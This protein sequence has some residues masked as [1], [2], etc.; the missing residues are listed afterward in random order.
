MIKTFI[1]EI[2]RNCF[3]T[4]YTEVALLPSSIFAIV[5]R[6]Y[7]YEQM[8]LAVICHSDCWIEMINPVTVWCEEN[9]KNDWHFSSNFFYFYDKADAMAFK[10]RW[11]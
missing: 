11:L 9:C 8:A 5:Q 7:S 1:R 4:K 6:S 3:S 10:L 2:K